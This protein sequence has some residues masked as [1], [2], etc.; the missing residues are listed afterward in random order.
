MR[1]LYGKKTREEKQLKEELARQEKGRGV[2][3]QELRT[4]DEQAKNSV[5]NAVL[6]ADQEVTEYMNMVKEKLAQ[7][8]EELVEARMS[9]EDVGDEMLMDLENYDR[10]LAAAC[11]KKRREQ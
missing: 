4:M 6:A 8:E 11:D 9:I 7:Q 3:Y 10:R 5:V 1:D 2:S